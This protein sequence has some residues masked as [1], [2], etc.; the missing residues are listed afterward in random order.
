MQ[1]P[2]DIRALVLSMLAMAS[3]GP[4]CDIEG[5]T[6]D[7]SAHVARDA[8]D[9]PFCDAFFGKT[10]EIEVG[11]SGNMLGA[12]VGDLVVVAQPWARMDEYLWTVDC[13]D[14]DDVTFTNL[15]DE[16]MLSAQ[17][18]GAPVVL[19]PASMSL[20]A[21]WEL[22]ESNGPW[23]LRSQY[24]GAGFM[25]ARGLSVRT[26]IAPFEDRLTRFQIREIDRETP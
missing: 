26:D 23:E 20:E 7:V 12:G 25:Y 16:E 10:V 18:N 4:G 15:L 1:R 13:S 9:S 17:G 14:D 22:I 5:G 21:V 8:T 24:C 2:S 11:S 19:R 3:I 6:D